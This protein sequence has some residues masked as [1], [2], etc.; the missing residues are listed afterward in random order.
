LRGAGKIIEAS[1]PTIRLDATPSRPSML[2]PPS[3]MTDA[4][5]VATL[6]IYP[7]LGQAMNMLDCIHG[8]FVRRLIN[9]N[10]ISSLWKTI[11]SEKN[12]FHPVTLKIYDLDL[13]KLDPDTFTVNRSHI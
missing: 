13:H 6:P 8:G 11:S 7:G 12:I 2:P 5:P 1:A 4:L 3:F 9:T 10:K